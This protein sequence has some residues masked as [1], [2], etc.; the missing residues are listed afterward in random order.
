MCE[1][2]I[3]QFQNSLKSILHKQD[4]NPFF[5]HRLEAPWYINL[6]GNPDES[7]ALHKSRFYFTVNCTS[8]PE[9]QPM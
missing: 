8:F 4:I 7:K 5:F 1:V 3:N 2:F 9:F 6:S